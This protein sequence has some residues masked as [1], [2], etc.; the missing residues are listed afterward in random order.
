MSTAEKNILLDDSYTIDYG[1]T[2]EELEQQGKPD[3]P[4]G[5]QSKEEP[6]A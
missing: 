4:Q 2:S 6:E 5:S 1:Q 3:K